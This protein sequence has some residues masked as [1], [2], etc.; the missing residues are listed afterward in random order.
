MSDYEEGGYPLKLGIETVSLETINKSLE[1]FDDFLG[2]NTLAANFV[3]GG[4]ILDIGNIS[5]FIFVSK[6]KKYQVKKN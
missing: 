6:L 5:K 4:Y 3:L 1:Q 2:I